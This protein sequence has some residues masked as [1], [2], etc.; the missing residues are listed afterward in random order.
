MEKYNSV[1]LP[2]MHLEDRKGKNE[3]LLDDV[4]E[5]NSGSHYRALI[6]EANWVC[7]QPHFR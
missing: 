5:M 7:H 1:S 3:Y 6:S 2:C 4:A